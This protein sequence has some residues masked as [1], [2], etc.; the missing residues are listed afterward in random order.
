MPAEARALVRSFLKFEM[1]ESKDIFFQDQLAW[2]T[3]EQEE[4]NR[5][6]LL[7]QRAVLDTV[8][9]DVKDE[10]EETLSGVGGAQTKAA[11]IKRKSQMRGI[12]D[13][14]SQYGG[15]G[16]GGSEQLQNLLWETASQGGTS[17]LHKNKA[18]QSRSI[19]KMHRIDENE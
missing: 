12:S 13:T 17:K 8:G 7:V 15:N 1:T 16:N 14:S 4:V 6:V 2:G 9:D 5:P 19:V 10:L 11:M 18:L 3:I